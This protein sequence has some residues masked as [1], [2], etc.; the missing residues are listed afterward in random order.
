[1]FTGEVWCLLFRA[2]MPKRSIFSTDPPHYESLPFKW[3]LQSST[4]TRLSP[5]T[6][7]FIFLPGQAH[8]SFSVLFN[9][10]TN[11]IEMMEK[12][13]GI[14]SRSTLCF[15]LLSL[16]RW[17]K[18]HLHMRIWSFWEWCGAKLLGIR[19]NADQP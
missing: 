5:C 14:W 3:L 7:I 1:M 8:L 19:R 4:F 12:I 10:L 15:F 2:F 17:Q 18:N 16:A 13:Y 9:V 6:G 11:L